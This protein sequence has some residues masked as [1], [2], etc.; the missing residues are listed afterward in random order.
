MSGRILGDVR[1]QSDMIC[2]VH[3]R[4]RES[5]PMDD[6]R[7]ASCRQSFW[8]VW[9]VLLALA[10]GVVGESLALADDG[11]PKAPTAANA[12]SFDQV[13]GPLFQTKCVRCHGKS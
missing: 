5:E 1:Y 7:A 6:A 2:I 4:T 13:I 10:L 8:F 11:A 9:F 12:P 3:T